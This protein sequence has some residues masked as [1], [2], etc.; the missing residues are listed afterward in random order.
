[1]ELS[2]LIELTKK[3]K[4]QSIKMQNR[5]LLYWAVMLFIVF[6]AILVVLSF[7]GV[8]SDSEEKAAQLINFQQNNTYSELS[9]ELEKFYGKDIS[10]SEEFSL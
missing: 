3:V 10:F 5:L 9:E 1:M 8:F 2:K 4:G 7:A 6:A